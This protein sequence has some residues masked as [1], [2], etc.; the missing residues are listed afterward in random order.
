MLKSNGFACISVLGE[1]KDLRVTVKVLAKELTGFSALMHSGISAQFYAW[2]RNVCSLRPPGEVGRYGTSEY[3]LRGIRTL[4]RRICW[5][6]LLLA[7][8]IY[9]RSYQ[10]GGKAGGELGKCECGLRVGHGI[11]KVISYG[12]DLFLSPEVFKKAVQ[13]VVSNEFIPTFLQGLTGTDGVS[14]SF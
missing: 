2:N 11:S 5:V 6:T 3:I 14:L 13:G 12:K 1:S 4:S 10:C 7:P 8:M 9:C